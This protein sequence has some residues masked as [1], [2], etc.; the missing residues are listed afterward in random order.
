MSIWNI[1]K[2]IAKQPNAHLNKY[3]LFS[4]NIIKKRAAMVLRDHLHI[5]PHSR[6]KEKH[7]EIHHVLQLEESIL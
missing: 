3:P 6:E 1:V 5:H 4:L 2:T 7:G